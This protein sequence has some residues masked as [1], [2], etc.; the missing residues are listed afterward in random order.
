MRYPEDLRAVA[1]RVIW[2]EEPKEA[3]K[4]PRRF[5]TYLMTYGAPDDVEVARRYYTDSDFE[6]ALDE[7]APGIF[8]VRSWEEWNIRYHRV[9]VPPL[10]KRVLPGERASEVPESLFEPRR[11]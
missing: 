7:P 1:R 8:D 5:L 3:L 11:S 2:F 10:P 4:Y 9:P 6:A